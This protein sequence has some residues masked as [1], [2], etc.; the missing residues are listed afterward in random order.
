MKRYLSALIMA[1][2]LV[3]MFSGCSL[4]GDSDIKTIT[5]MTN[6]TDIVDTTLREY[7]DKY[8]EK[9]PGIKIQLE[10]VSDYYRVAQTRAA[11]GELADVSYLMPA[12]KSSEW[13]DYYMPLNDLG[14]NGKFYFEDTYTYDGNLYAIPLQM[15]YSGVVYNK[16]A[17]EK[18]GIEEVPKT[19]D[20]LYE[21]S[22]KLK[23]AGITPTTPIFKEAGSMG[24]YIEYI[25]PLR[26][27]ADYQSDIVG[28]KNPFTVDSPVGK[29]LKIIET[30]YERDFF[31]E[32]LMSQ[33]SDGMK[34][35]LAQGKLG[36]FF[37]QT[38]LVPQIVSNGGNSEDIGFFPMPIDGRGEY[39]TLL[40]PDVRLAI[41]KDTKY[42]EETKAFVKYLMETDYENFVKVMGGSISIR[43]DSDFS[44]MPQFDEFEAY[45]PEKV[46]FVNDPDELKAAFNKAQIKWDDMAH[47]VINLGSVEEC[48]KKY[49]K[50]WNQALEDLK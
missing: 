20:E 13:A 19:L 9:N 39:K 35:D 2:L 14:L 10:A 23:K 37:S 5:F 40:K 4:G 32:D 1:L 8:E 46:E 41:S 3:G 44:I 11:A 29:S 48:L 17:F 43:K 21:A 31:E 15:N 30:L 42:P 34:Q 25:A 36:W 26:G 12:L 27:K 38:W 24:P 22:E 47:D 50:L 16:K 6:K 49:N 7:A 45:N 28:K 33:T 18:A